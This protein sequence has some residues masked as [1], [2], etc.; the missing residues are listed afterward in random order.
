MFG[1]TTTLRRVG[2]AAGIA[3]LLTA[4]SAYAA[5]TPPDRADGLYGTNPTLH[6]PAV[7]IPDRLDAIGS[8]RFPGSTPPTVIIRTVNSDQGFDWFAAAAGA[9]AMLGVVGL[10]A[11]AT[12]M[13]AR[14]QVVVPG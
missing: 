12:A 11:A 1:I 6:A 9:L 13:R 7:S 3:C 5:T 2:I 8:A 14:R 4:G 10:G